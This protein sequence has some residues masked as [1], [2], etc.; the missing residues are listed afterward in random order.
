MSCFAPSWPAGALFTVPNSESLDEEEAFALALVGDVLDEG[1]IISDFFRRPNARLNRLPVT[2]DELPKQ[3]GVDE[4][5]NAVFTG[6]RLTAWPIEEAERE[7][8]R[9]WEEDNELGTP[10]LEV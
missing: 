1:R 10:S 6:G 4:E 8:R 9:L 7:E 5:G 2:D 3:G